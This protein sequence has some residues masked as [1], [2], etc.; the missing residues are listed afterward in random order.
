MLIPVSP[1]HEIQTRVALIPFSC[2]F[3]KCSSHQAESKSAPNSFQ[4]CQGVL[5]PLIQIRFVPA[6][7]W[8]PATVIR[9]AVSVARLDAATKAKR[10]NKR[11]RPNQGKPTSCT[12]VQSAWKTPGS[13]DRRCWHLKPTPASELTRR[14]PIADPLHGLAV[15][16]PPTPGR[17]PALPLPNLLQMGIR[18]IQERFPIRSAHDMR[19]RMIVKSE[20]AGDQRHVHGWGISFG[21][22]IPRA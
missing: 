14:G 20:V 19:T 6:L 7:N 15:G 3:W 16:A 10:S 5:A 21:S 4:T 2:S 22:K 18:K 9:S 1:L 13:Q 17:R 11:T 12:Q 8:A